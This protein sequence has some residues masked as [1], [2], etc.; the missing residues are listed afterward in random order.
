MCVAWNYTQ[1]VTKQMYEHTFIASASSSPESL[2]GISASSETELLKVGMLQVGP[3]AVG[4]F[5]SIAILYVSL[6]CSVSDPS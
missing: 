6:A 2:E 5:P 3:F 1:V 4:W